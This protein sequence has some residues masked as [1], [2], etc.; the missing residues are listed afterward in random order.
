M[1]GNWPLRQTMA[2]I[3]P[4]CSMVTARGAPAAARRPSGVSSTRPPPADVT[5]SKGM[6]AFLLT[7]N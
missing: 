2:R 4:A 3:G 5:D 1:P 6:N 7:T